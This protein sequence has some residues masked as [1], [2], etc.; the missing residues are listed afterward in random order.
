MANIV[1]GINNENI[2]DG[3]ATTKDL[4][5]YTLMRGVTDFANL[6]AY[7]LY[8]TGYSFLV[9]VQAPLCL[10]KLSEINTE[11]GK[12]VDTYIHIL[13]YDFRGLNGLQN[14]TAETQ[15]LTNGISSVEIINKVTLPE[16]SSFTMQYFER[17]GSV[18]SKTHELFLRGL[19]D[20]RTQ[21]KHYNGLIDS[22][23]LKAGYENEVFAFMYIVTDNTL[24]NVEKA[25]Y[26]VAAQPTEANFDQYNSTKGTIEFKEIDVEFKGYPIFG[27]EVNRKAK[28]LL[29]YIRINTV[30]NEMDFDYSYKGYGAPGV[31]DR[32]SVK[33][34]KPVQNIVNSSGREI[35]YNTL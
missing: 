24:M 20:P 1:S 33:D 31:G 14:M 21:R 4:S 8:E 3:L 35:P 25:V 18:I 15:N 9:V 7:N 34:I 22:G 30:W 12:L 17:Y 5:K 19:K 28:D 16:T 10:T 32:L 26:I 6:S 13:E 2:F 27:R 23:R 29:D 11:Y